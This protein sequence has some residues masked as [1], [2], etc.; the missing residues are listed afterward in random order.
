MIVIDYTVWVCTVLELSTCISDA[1]LGLPYTS[2]IGFVGD[3][4]CPPRPLTLVGDAGWSRD[5]AVFI[6][7]SACKCTC[8]DVSFAGP[9]CHLHFCIPG[10]HLIKV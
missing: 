9:A 4:E 1:H 3:N 8:N 7:S 6:K 2:L 10:K 5:C